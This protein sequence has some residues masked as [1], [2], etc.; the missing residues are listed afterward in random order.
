MKTVVECLGSV[1]KAS[2]LVISFIFGLGWTAYISVHTI[3][4]AEGKE[5]RREVNQ[6]RSVDMQHLDKRFD[7]LEKLIQG[8]R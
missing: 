7:T 3:V 5:I 2:L 8:K 6:L 1:L 4:K